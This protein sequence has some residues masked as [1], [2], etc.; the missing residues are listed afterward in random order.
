MHKRLSDCGCRFL[1]SVASSERN[2][3]GAD[4]LNFESNGL[5]SISAC[6]PFQLEIFKTRAVFSGIKSIRVPVL[7][8]VFSQPKKAMKNKNKMS[9]PKFFPMK[10]NIIRIGF[11]AS[12]LKVVYLNK[13]RSYNSEITLPK[14]WLDLILRSKEPLSKGMARV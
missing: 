13:R 3:Y 11:G 5:F 6:S 4:L 1:S 2:R 12:F 10:T 9:F 14:Q 8:G 7:S